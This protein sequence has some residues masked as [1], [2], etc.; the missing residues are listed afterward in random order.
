MVWAVHNKRIYH[1][2]Q[3][4]CYKFIVIRIIYS[5]GQSIT[6]LP[7]IRYHYKIAHLHRPFYKAIKPIFARYLLQKQ[8]C[9]PSKYS[10]ILCQIVT[11]ILI[12]AGVIPIIVIASVQ[13]GNH[14]ILDCY[15]SPRECCE[16]SGCDG[17]WLRRLFVELRLW[18]CRFYLRLA[19]KHYRLRYRTD[20][21]LHL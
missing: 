17:L 14:P 19:G 15:S 6:N 11:F 8:V 21:L 16:I 13:Y 2:L 10:L 18:L 12:V 1:A 3:F 7:P 4:K 5:F 9:T 20:P